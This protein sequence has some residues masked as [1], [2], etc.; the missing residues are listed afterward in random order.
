DISEI[1]IEWMQE[2]LSAYKNIIPMRM[3]DNKICLGDETADF[4]FMINLHH[5]LDR[6]DLALKECYRLLKKGAKIVVSDWKKA[7]MDI[8]PPLAIRVSPDDVEQQLL[9][10]GFRKVEIYHEAEFN[11]MLV[12]G[13]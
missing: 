5:E 1:M 6:P 7:Q 2:H 13:K 11:Y 3:E 8:G 4:L 12:A 10:A 9:K